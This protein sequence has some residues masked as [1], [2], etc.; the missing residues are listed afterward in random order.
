MILC[1]IHKLHNS[2]LS[3]SG[4]K[5]WVYSMNRREL[6]TQPWGAPVLSISVGAVWPIWT[7]CGLFMRES[8]IQLQ[9]VVLMSKVQSLAISFMGERLLRYRFDG[10]CLEEDGNTL[11][12]QWHGWGCNQAQHLCS[13]SLCSGCFLHALWI[14]TVAGLLEA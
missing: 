12:W 3:I 6:S 1:V 7:V 5:S 8:N 14:L 13:Y 11:L 9:S 4:L 2:L 10:G